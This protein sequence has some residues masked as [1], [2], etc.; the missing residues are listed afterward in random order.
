[1]GSCNIEKQIIKKERELQT[2]KDSKDILDKNKGK[3]KKRKS[4]GEI[5]INNISK[6][7]KKGN[8]KNNK[9]RKKR[10]G[11]KK[12]L[13][14]KIENFIGVIKINNRY[15]KENNKLFK[16]IVKLI[17]SKGGNTKLLKYK[18]DD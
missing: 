2:L 6:T 16:T 12:Q 1:M 10:S 9:R 5:Y 18:N 15:Q 17:N 8:V 13:E 4:E 3:S 11:D 7:E 14:D